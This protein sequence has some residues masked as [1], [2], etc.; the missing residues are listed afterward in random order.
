MGNARSLAAPRRV[1]SS[2]S[3]RTT[4]STKPPALKFLPDV[5]RDGT[6]TLAKNQPRNRPG[7]L[8][9]NLTQNYFSGA[10]KSGGWCGW[11]SVSRHGAARVLVWFIDAD[12]ISDAEL[13]RFILHQL[14]SDRR[15]GLSL[16]LL[17]NGLPAELAVECVALQR[18][19]A[20]MLQRGVIRLSST[21]ICDKGLPVP[22]AAS[23]IV[24]SESSAAGELAK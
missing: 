8:E 11:L 7:S 16:A 10:R 18:V 22:Q 24:D 17:R 21:L 13:K 19:L 2:A 4:R 23:A 1:D 12:P 6:K 20:G 15:G 5:A 9:S 14:M 3:H